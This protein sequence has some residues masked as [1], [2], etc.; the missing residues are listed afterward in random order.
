MVVSREIF[1]RVG[2]SVG[3]VCN[4]FLR[5]GLSLAVGST[6]F[7]GRGVLMVVGGVFFLGGRGVDWIWWF[8]F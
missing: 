6:R 8:I 3:S 1:L 4:Y 5:Y 2:I 7:L